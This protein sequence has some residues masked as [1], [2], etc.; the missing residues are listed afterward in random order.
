MKKLFTI[1]GVL[2]LALTLV[3]CKDDPI[4]EDPKDDP[5]TEVDLVLDDDF[6]GIA[7][8][9]IYL[10]TVGQVD[11]DIVESLLNDETIGAGVSESE[12]TRQDDL[13]AADLTGTLPVVLLVTGTSSKGLGAAG[14]DVDGEKSRGE[15]F[16]QKADD[17]EI[18]LVVIHVGGSS[19]RGALTDPILNAVCPSANI[20]L[21][22]ETGDHDGIFTNLSTDNN[23]P[24]YLFSKSSK[25]VDA[26]KTLFD[27]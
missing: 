16:A 17:G 12:Y 4:D 2:F 20:I 5:N 13:T 15:A 18:I 23:V 21:V 1:F 27:K 22:V 24:L 3:A 10:T 8:G 9:N 19:R 25:M 11:I 14:T 6:K 26:F 7:T